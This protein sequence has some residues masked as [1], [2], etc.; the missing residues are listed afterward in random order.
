MDRKQ[1]TGRELK[2]INIE[3][4]QQI[5]V[6][7]IDMQMNWSAVVLLT[8]EKLKNTFRGLISQTVLDKGTL[9]F[10]S[11]LGKR[12]VGAKYM[13][14]NIKQTARYISSKHGF[15]WDHRKLQFGG[16]QPWSTQKCTQSKGKRT[17][18]EEEAGR[19]I[20]NKEPMAFH[21]LSPCQERREIFI[22]PCW[23]LLDNRV[24]E[25][26]FWSPDCIQLW[27]MFLNFLH[28]PL[29]TKSFY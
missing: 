15:I 22:P 5:S 8:W 7:Y 9:R 28:F 17:F 21:W 27:F 6:E 3:G 1:D 12:N 23:A 10:L 2:L 18:I 25:L 19:V 26:P 16:L 11:Y 13:S 4:T 14:C 20:A 29:F 24:W